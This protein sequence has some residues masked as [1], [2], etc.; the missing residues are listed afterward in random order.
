V[1]QA[2]NVELKTSALWPQGDIRDPLGIWG[3]RLGVTG[4]ATAGEIKVGIQAAQA[5]RAAYI[6]TCYNANVSV[7]LASGVLAMTAF[8]RLL[9]NWPDIDPVAGVQGYG[10][11]IGRVLGITIGGTAPE[12]AVGQ[13]LVL[14]QERFILLFDPRPQPSEALTIVELKVTAQVDADT[15]SFEAY[16]YYWDRSVLDAP[17]GPRHPGT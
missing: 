4:D 11:N 17:G 6:Y 7:L 16:G 10:S 12:G 9:T 3:A 5:E 1:S 14:P 15:Y 13:P 2:L 8:C